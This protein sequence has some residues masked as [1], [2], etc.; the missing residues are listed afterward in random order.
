VI[1]Q[2]RRVFDLSRLAFCFPVDDG[3]CFRAGRPLTIDPLGYRGS[4]NVAH[5]SELLMRQVIIPQE[6]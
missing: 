2:I 5:I 6:L 1:R 3:N 4:I